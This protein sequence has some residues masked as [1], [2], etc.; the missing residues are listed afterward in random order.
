MLA[1]ATRCCGY[2]T[3]ACPFDN[4]QAERDLRMVKLQQKISRCW[5]T[6]DDAEAFLTLRSYLSTAH[7]HGMKS[8]RRAPP[9]VPGSPLATSSGGVLKGVGFLH[10][11]INPH[12]PDPPAKGLHQGSG[13]LVG[14][15][16]MPRDPTKASRQAECLR[17]ADQDGKVPVPRHLVQHDAREYLV[18]SRA[19]PDD[20]GDPHLDEA[21]LRGRGHGELPQ[22][23]EPIFLPEPS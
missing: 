15:R 4:N 14:H 1:I 12:L 21:N 17:L 2:W 10:Q 3:T 16:T 7:K 23:P 20:L 5:R 19:K 13:E 11:P 8:A 22:P 9:A 18:L 6:L